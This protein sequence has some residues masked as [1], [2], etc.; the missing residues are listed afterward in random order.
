VYLFYEQA[1]FIYCLFIKNLLSEGNIMLTPKQRMLNAYK[2]IFSDHY[3]VAPEFWNYYPAKIIGVNMIEFE[4]IHFWEALK[5]TF[6][7][8]HTEGWANENA[9]FLNDEIK[10]EDSFKKLDSGKYRS[11]C[12]RTYKG[13]EFTSSRLYDEKEPS[14]AEEFPVKN[15]RELGLYIDMVLSERT[16]FDFKK[17]N[18]AYKGVGEDY[19]I[20]FGL[21]EPFFDFIASA[22]GYTNAI[23][24]FYQA[25]KQL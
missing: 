13:H 22:M 19:L 21:G 14:W 24:F 4:K 8:Y 2:G 10:T 7:I 17:A 11:I 5:K 18:I 12:K 6:N 15:E 25:M 3:P 1:V 23:Y 20:E 16:Q 9:E